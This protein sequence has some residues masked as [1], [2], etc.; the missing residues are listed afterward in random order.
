MPKNKVETDKFHVRWDHPADLP[1]LFAL[2]SYYFGRPL[3]L[4]ENIGPALTLT[5]PFQI[6]SKPVNGPLPFS[7][8]NVCPIYSMPSDCT[9]LF[10]FKDAKR[11]NYSRTFELDETAAYRN[12]QTFYG[13][14][15]DFKGVG[16]RAAIKKLN[17]N[18]F[19]ETAFR[20]DLD[21]LDVKKRK[22]NDNLPEQ[23]KETYFTHG[24]TYLAKIVAHSEFDSQTP[25]LAFEL[26]QNVSLEFA[27]RNGRQFSI[28]TILEVCYQVAAGMS[29]LEANKLCH[30]GLCANN[31]IVHWTDAVSVSVKIT[32]YML[33]YHH[34][35]SKSDSKSSSAGSSMKQLRWQ[36]MSPESLFHGIF[37]IVADSWSYGCL[38]FEI[39]NGGAVPFLHE[40]PKIETPENLK[41]F[42]LS[43][44]KM[45][46][47]PNYDG[48]EILKI[49]FQNCFE[50]RN[51]RAPFIRIVKMLHNFIFDHVSPAKVKM[52]KGK[53][54]P[55]QETET[56]SV[57]PGPR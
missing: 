25:F 42:V 10:M 36:W 8:K 52:V 57:E 4:K 46:L 49:I 7:E 13:V 28:L 23:N 11:K 5:Q 19:D 24:S 34:L 6:L 41:D 18:W 2:L 30:R 16:I 26:I 38:I 53:R 51:S 21:L 44:K 15:K 55:Y 45:Q 22:T 39:F 12:S 43:K 17:K 31:V 33:P 29:H 14:A 9:G 3:P 37:D 56:V 48:P 27:L 54:I 35:A 1:G 47:N 20:A 50:E 32:D 40:E